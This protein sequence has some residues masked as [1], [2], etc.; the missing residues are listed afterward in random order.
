MLIVRTLRTLVVAVGLAIGVAAQD[1]QPTP[2]A[3]PS[4]GDVQVYA[5]VVDT[6]GAL[7]ADLDRQGFE[8][9]D[10]GRRRPLTSFQSSTQPVNVVIMIDGSA[11]ME[12]MQEQIRISADRVV[13]QLGPDDRARIGSFSGKV[14]I[15][16]HGT[17]DRVALSRA[18]NA[19]KSGD[20][21]TM[22]WDAIDL[23]IA[24][25][26]SEPGRRVVLVFTDGDDTGS[27]RENFNRVVER[28]QADD[29]M[30]YA[31]G[32]TRLV[33]GTN[34]LRM[35]SYPP[36]GRLRRLADETGGGY[37][38]LTPKTDLGATFA[39]VA[40]E[41]RRQYLLGFTPDRPDGTMHEL[42]VTLTGPGLHVRARLQYR[43]PLP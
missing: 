4:P 31:V 37:V 10:G 5:T 17:S 11:S 9:Y 43:A 18:L 26:A 13:A 25:V 28:A 40:D 7:V 1:A 24:A 20:A 39:R 30:I 38:E 35:L 14:V 32:V 12:L 41:L 34:P 23:A 42:R 33:P 36:N 29:V 21:P 3:A 16:P 27:R 8:I 15:T 6:S 19:S 2:I 22:L